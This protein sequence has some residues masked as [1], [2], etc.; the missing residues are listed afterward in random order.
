MLCR[1]GLLPPSLDF[2]LL[3]GA[4]PAKKKEDERPATKK[5]GVIRFGSNAHADAAVFTPDGQHLITGT[6]DGF[7]EV[8]NYDTCKVNTDLP[9][10]AKDKFMMHDD[11]VQ[12]M[13]VSTDS[14]LLATGARNGKIKVWR[15]A[16]GK[17]VRKFPRAHEEGVGSVEFNL[18]STQLLSGSSDMTARYVC[19]ARRVGAVALWRLI[20]PFSLCR[21]HG[22]LSGKLLKEFR[23]HTSYVNTAVYNATGHRVLTGSSD[24]TMKVCAC[25]A[26]SA[27]CV[28]V[29]VW[30]CVAVGVHV[31]SCIVAHVHRYPLRMQLW[32]VKSTD[33]LRSFRLPQE[34]PGVE[35]PVLHCMAMPKRKDCFL[36]C[37]K[38]PFV[39]LI[40]SEGTVLRKLEPHLPAKG[41]NFVACIASAKVRAAC[42]PTGGI[43]PRG[44][45]C[46]RVNVWVAPRAP[47]FTHYVKTR[48]CTCSRPATATSWR[49]QTQPTATHRHWRYTHTGTCSARWRRIAS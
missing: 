47:T 46:V 25:V 14:E 49:L 35:V 42:F 3:R 48:K 23:G 21:V 39:F 31:P 29:A 24:G 41:G 7:V 22:L 44:N 17:C 1:Q 28:A 32:D 6:V 45:Q 11:A 15:L 16:S 26:L 12:C 30:H 19:V 10:Q 36:V 37:N 5:A 2:D 13:A 38:S 4:A 34:L 43:R 40:T 8:W 18:D 20:A 33:C 9:Y 27:A